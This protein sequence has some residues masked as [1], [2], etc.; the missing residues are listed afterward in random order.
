MRENH[1][2]VFLP[3]DADRENF[4]GLSAPSADKTENINVTS[5]DIRRFGLEPPSG[6]RLGPSV[7]VST[8]DVAQLGLSA[9]AGDD[10]GADPASAADVARYGA[11]RR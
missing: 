2:V 1:S 7:P 6:A 3:A 8:S 10:S 11:A 9:P 5:D 4:P